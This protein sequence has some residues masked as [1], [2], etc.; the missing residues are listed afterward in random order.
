MASLSFNEYSDSPT[1][2]FPPHHHS[3]DPVYYHKP[4]PCFPSASQRSFRRTAVPNTAAITMNPSKKRGRCDE[5]EET[6][7]TAMPV[8][9]ANVAPA[10]VEQ[11]QL[12]YG[13]G[14][15]LI[16]PRSGLAASAESQT[17][18]WYEEQLEHER[19]ETARAAE[20]LAKIQAESTTPPSNKIHRVIAPSAAAIDTTPKSATQCNSELYVNPALDTVKHL[21][22]TEWACISE[23]QLLRS[24]SRGWAKFVDRHYP[25]LNN[26]E[27]L[28]RLRGK[29]AYLIRTNEGLFLFNDDL[30]QGRLVAKTWETCVANL[31]LDPIFFEGEESLTAIKEPGHS[32]DMMDDVSGSDESLQDTNSSTEEGAGAM[33][34]D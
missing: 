28:L 15:T 31:V 25:S 32:V 17:G 5:D 12:V 11:P 8:P 1:L 29:N 33:E 19:L 21:L 20:L 30:T 10:V 9:T 4:Y 14:M 26:V 3:F 34:I 27:V 2:F 13:E 23:D 6:M 24:A 22:G 18:T 16:D 7:D